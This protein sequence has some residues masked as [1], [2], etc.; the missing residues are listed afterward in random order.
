MHHVMVILSSRAHSE[1][2]RVFQ[3]VPFPR[4]KM[5]LSQSLGKDSAIPPISADLCQSAY[6]MLGDSEMASWHH[7]I[8]TQL[9]GLC[10]EKGPTAARCG[11]A[12]GSTE[13]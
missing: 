3:R 1:R 13:R 2:V 7:G 11:G 10:A 5:H 12:E 4:E 9:V 6:Q 8:A